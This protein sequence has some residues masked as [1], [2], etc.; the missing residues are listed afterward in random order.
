[1]IGIFRGSSGSLCFVIDT[2]NSMSDDIAAVKNVTSSII[3]SKVGTDDEPSL[4]ILVPFNDPG[5]VLK[6]H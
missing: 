1:M 2:T 6:M 5:R 4:Y 3:T